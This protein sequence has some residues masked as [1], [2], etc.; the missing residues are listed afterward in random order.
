MHWITCWFCLNSFLSQN[1]TL[2]RQI[3][4]A[5]ELPDPRAVCYVLYRIPALSHS[6]LLQNGTLS[7]Q[8]IT[9]I[10][11]PD[12]KAVMEMMSGPPDR[13]QEFLE[14]QFNT[15]KEVPWTRW[16]PGELEYYAD[17]LQEKLDAVH[18]MLE[19]MGDYHQNDP[20]VR[21]QCGCVWWDQNLFFIL[22][23]RHRCPAVQAR[24]KTQKV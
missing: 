8:I 22:A 1:Y 23:A 10:E 6:F 18:R 9:A 4:A 11:L 17:G 13:Y 14:S 15:A 16:V 24:E 12:P 7:R 5:L 2:Y 20:E 21:F 19:A 3:T